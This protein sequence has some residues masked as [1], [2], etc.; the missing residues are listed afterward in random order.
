MTGRLIQFLAGLATVV[1]LV[2]VGGQTAF[3]QPADQ[4]TRSEN[5]IFSD[6][7]EN[8]GDMSRW[9]SSD[10]MFVQDDIAASGKYAARMISTGLPTFA[11]YGLPSGVSDVYFRMRVQV[12]SLGSNSADLVGFRTA[13]NEQLWTLSVVPG[14]TLSA[15]KHLTNEVIASETPVTTGRW[16]EIQVHFRSEGEQSFV[17]VWVEGTSISKFTGPI[18][19]PNI[20]AARIELGDSQLGGTFDVA[21]DDVIIGTARIPT[22]QKP[23]PIPGELAISTVPAIEGIPFEL[24]GIVSYTNAAGV[25]RIQVPNWNPD[26][27]SQIK[28][29]IHTLPDGRQ[30]DFAQWSNWNRASNANV[31]ARFDI[32][33]PISWNFVDLQGDP[34]DPSRVQEITFKNS[35]GVLYT[36]KTDQNGTVQMVHG[37]RVVPTTEGLI[38][39]PLYYTLQ[40]AIVDGANVVNQNQQRYWPTEKSSWGIE[41]LFFAAEFQAK[42]ALFGYPLGET[43]T[44]VYPSGL[45]RQEQLD[46]NGYLRLDGLPRGEYQV[47]V[48]GPGYSPARPIALSRNQLVELEI[49]SYL[50]M[51]VG[52]GIVVALALGLLF[53][54]RPSIYR[55]PKRWIRQLVPGGRR[56]RTLEESA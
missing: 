19:L 21:F 17:E 23:D 49:V 22:A 28:S 15:Y 43:V 37:S 2:A 14:E 9:E 16:Y 47:S 51:A 24:D 29:P 11:R 1:V 31:V 12:V 36:F 20:V 41:L 54:G 33:Y 7:F 3:S 5:T 39:K 38:V 48:S 8:Y 30:T 18:S 55:T 46:E 45:V 13:D 4:E 27:Q 53:I 52:A 32:S 42:D 34:V 56:H 40:S 10:A 25:V 50:D 44:L 6:G 35:V 26:L